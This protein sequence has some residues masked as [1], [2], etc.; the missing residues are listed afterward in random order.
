[1]PT[2]QW[3]ARPWP[4][5]A[6]LYPG[7]LCETHPDQSGPAPNEALA[8]AYYA[9]WL[10][11]DKVIAAA[12]FTPNP[13]RDTISYFAA[14]AARAGEAWGLALC[15]LLAVIDPGHCEKALKRDGTA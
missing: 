5:P 14:H 6:P 1:M 8:L 10:E 3:G 12:I 9:F 13:D 15:R 7:F 11:L 4:P 2:D